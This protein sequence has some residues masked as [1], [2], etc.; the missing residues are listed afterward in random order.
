MVGRALAEGKNGFDAFKDGVKQ[1]LGEIASAIG[2]L[3]IKWGIANIAS[4]NYAVGGA[5]LVAGAALKTLAGALGSSGGGGGAGAGSVSSGGGINVGDGGL[6]TPQTSLISDE[7]ERAEAQSSLVV[8]VN[9]DVFDS[10]ETG[11]RLVN[12]INDTFG[13]KGVAL[14]DVRTA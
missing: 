5:Q 6:A 11:N 12:I 3:I 14:T 7:S 9:G 2:D 13:K 1:I 4:Q 10:E 8:N